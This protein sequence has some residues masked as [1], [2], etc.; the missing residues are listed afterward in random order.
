[1]T[2]LKPK[3]KLDNSSHIVEDNQKAKQKLLKLSILV[4]IAITDQIELQTYTI[5]KKREIICDE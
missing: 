1:M 4:D 2:K 5:R 3:T